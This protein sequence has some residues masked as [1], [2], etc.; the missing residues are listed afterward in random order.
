M[1]PWLP[2]HSV[3]AQLPAPR[4]LGRREPNRRHRRRGGRPRSGRPARVGR[5]PGDAAGAGAG[6]RRQ[7]RPARPGRLTCS[8]PGPRFSPCREVFEDFF[9]DTGDPLDRV[10]P[11]RRVDPLTC[12]RWPDGTRARPARRRPATGPALDAAL[13][14]GAGAQWLRLLDAGPGSRRQP[15]GRSWKLPSPARHAGPARRAPSRRHSRHLARRD[16][17]WARPPHAH[18]RTAPDAARSLRHLQRLRPAAGARCPGHDP[19]AGAGLGGPG[20]SPAAC[21]GWGWPCATARPNTA[22]T[23][24]AG[25][26]SPPSTTAGGR[27]DGRTAG[28]RRPAAGR[29]RRGDDRRRGRLPQHA[30]RP[31]A[32]RPV[33][34]SPAPARS[35]SGFVLL[36]G[37]QGRTPALGHHTVF[38]P[39]DYDAEFDA[40]FAGRL[41]DDPTIY[42]SKPDDPALVPDPDAESWFVLVNAAPHGSGTGQLDWTAP[43]AGLSLRRPQCSTGSRSTAST[44]GTGSPRCDIR[45]P[46]D[47]ERDTGSPGGSI[48]GVSCQ[49]PGLRPAPSDEPIAGEGPVPGRRVGSPRR[50]S[51]PRRTLGEDRRRPHRAG[52]TAPAGPRAIRARERP[53]F[54][55]SSRSHTSAPRRRF[56]AVSNLGQSSLMAPTLVLM[57]AGNPTTPDRS[58]CSRCAVGACLEG[59]TGPSVCSCALETDEPHRR[60]CVH[61]CHAG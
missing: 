60:A 12:Y 34:G 38:F 29:R 2:P 17:A 22:W 48:Y 37:L 6:G 27:V 45:T 31:P 61:E 4:G 59:Q 10:L 25:R 26:G 50:G 9:A 7:T 42:V 28:R 57:C 16:A 11:L 8:T 33:A 46:A 24:V 21:T 30:R 13:G 40:V 3:A 23:S 41:A 36:L 20:T 54:S 52:V 51:P 15:A 32:R 44:S 56:V 5:S 47:I 19:V 18:G 53:T 58:S 43:G 49:R 35:M 14:P 55:T 39:R 1:R